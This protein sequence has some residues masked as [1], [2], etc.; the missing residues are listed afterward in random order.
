VTIWHVGDFGRFSMENRQF[1]RFEVISADKKLGIVTVWYS[2]QETTTNIPIAT[3]QKDCVNW[4]DI[5]ILGPV[6][7]NAAVTSEWLFP[8]CHLTLESATR[9][10][11]V[12]ITQ[13]KHHQYQRTTQGVDV[14]GRTL[15]YRRR[16]G[17]YVSC[18][19]EDPKSL[20]LIPLKTVLWYGRPIKTRWDLI[21]T[22][23]IIDLEE[24]LF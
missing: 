2:G 23:D 6:I 7:S 20:L 12:T 16:Q 9:A 5:E 4:W 3:F 21:R 10:I 13:I 17:D 11:N 24:E 15:L 8:G 19:T 1:P 18:L 14:K 22:R